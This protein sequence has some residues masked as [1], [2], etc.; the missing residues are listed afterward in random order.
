MCCTEPVKVG[1]PTWADAM[2]AWLNEQSENRSDLPLAEWDAANQVVKFY[3]LRDATTEELWDYIRVEE[4]PYS[5]LH[6]K[7]YPSIGCAPCTRAVEP[8]EHPRAGRWWWEQGQE[9]NECGLHF[10]NG[11]TARAKDAEHAG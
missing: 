2:V 1:H 7:G 4:V 5:P 8:R 6:D 11:K 10:V 9:V 3:P